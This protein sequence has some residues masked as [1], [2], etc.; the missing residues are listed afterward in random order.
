VR[1]C[2]GL[3]FYNTNCTVEYARYMYVFVRHSE[4]RNFEL[5]NAVK[6]VETLHV[7]DV[8]SVLCYNGNA[9]LFYIGCL[10]V[11]RYAFK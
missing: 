11:V 8:I 4:I 3:V 5:Y 1:N 7:C 6:Y 9:Y 2:C 10:S